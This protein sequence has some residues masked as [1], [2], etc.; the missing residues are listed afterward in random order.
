MLP[1]DLPKTIK[2]AV[3]AV[4]EPKTTTKHPPTHTNTTRRRTSVDA[5]APLHPFLACFSDLFFCTSKSRETTIKALRDTM[6]SRI[7]VEKVA[8]M[9]YES[10]SFSFDYA[11]LCLVASVLS[12]IGL[13]TNSVVIIVASMLVSPLMGPILAFTFGY[14]DDSSFLHNTFPTFP[15]SPPSI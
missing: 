13:V 3:D 12:C 15:F 2:K 6:K 8:E 9:V 4:L 10:S 1:L 7:A 11:M 5:Q 14:V